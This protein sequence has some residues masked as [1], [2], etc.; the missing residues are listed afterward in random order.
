MMMLG[1]PPDPCIMMLGEPAAPRMDPEAEMGVLDWGDDACD[2]L[3]GVLKGAVLL[4]KGGAVPG[5]VG[6]VAPAAAGDAMKACALAGDGGACILPWE[7]E[8][9]AREVPTPP[10]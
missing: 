7:S 5:G 10:L 4:C 3:G 8:P 6:P 2:G 1:E 9:E